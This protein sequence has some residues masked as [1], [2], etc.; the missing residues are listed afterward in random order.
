MR[1]KW[2]P[3]PHSSKSSKR[4]PGRG[5]RRRRND[6]FADCQEPVSQLNFTAYRIAGSDLMSIL[7]IIYIICAVLVLFGAAI[8]L[9]ELGHF[10]VARWLGMKVEEFAIGMGPKMFSW[11]RNGL[12]YSV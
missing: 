8:F 10:L 4:T 9:H 6:R 1:T 12:V 11:T 5:G 3:I 7:N 2:W